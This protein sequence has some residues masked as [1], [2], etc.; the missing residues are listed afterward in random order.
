MQSLTHGSNNNEPNN[1][2]RTGHRIFAALLLLCVI[3]LGSCCKK[4]SNVNT[5]QSQ[6][7]P[8]GNLQDKTWVTI[9]GI[10]PEIATDSFKSSPISLGR[11]FEMKYNVETAQQLNLHLS[12]QTVKAGADATKWMYDISVPPNGTRMITIP[13][14]WNG[15]Y[16]PGGE[17][18]LYFHFS[19]SGAYMFSQKEVHIIIP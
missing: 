15:K 7:S 19:G 4:N 8:N 11:T 2:Q 1:K 10:N 16:I 18:R 13:Q 5:N 14:Q 9:G 6:G 3:S 17:Y 12:L